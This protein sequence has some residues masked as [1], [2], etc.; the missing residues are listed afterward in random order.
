[1]LKSL[2]IVKVGMMETTEEGRRFRMWQ[3]IVFA[4]VLVVVAV[5]LDP[6]TAWG[7]LVQ[8]IAQLAKACIGVYAFYWLMR[9][10]LHERTHECQNPEVR[11]N[12]LVIAYGLVFAAIMMAG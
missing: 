7:V 1:M 4:M 6:L 11:G 12:Y 3:A 9:G 8:G 2:K 5:Y 10:V